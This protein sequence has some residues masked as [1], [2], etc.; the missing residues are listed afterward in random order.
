MRRHL[1]AG[2]GLSLVAL[3]LFLPPA[4]PRSPFG[5][6]IRVV[7]AAGERVE[8]FSVLRA[9]A[10]AGNGQGYSGGDPE[11]GRL[12]AARERLRKALSLI[13][14]GH[15]PSGLCSPRACGPG[16]G[17]PALCHALAA[18]PSADTGACRA[19]LVETAAQLLEASSPERSPLALSA[20]PLTASVPGLPGRRVAALTPRAGG[21]IVVHAASVAASSRE[22]LVALLLHE[23]GHRVAW[24][25]GPIDDEVVVT[26]T[27][28][29]GAALLDAAGAAIALFS[30]T[31][32]IPAQAPPPVPEGGDRGAICARATDLES[33]YVLGLA[34]DSSGETPD[35]A[36]LA[37]WRGAAAS[38]I[39]AG[40]EDAV[41]RVALAATSSREARARFIDELFRLALLRKP[42]VS[43][44]E[45]TQSRLAAGLSYDAVVASVLGD[46][47]YTTAHAH[48]TQEQF[49]VSVFVDLV[50]RLPTAGEAAPYTASALD[51][52]TIAR[53][54]FR[55]EAGAAERLVREWFTRY[56]NREPGAAERDAYVAMVR[57]GLSW[58]VAR[59]RILSLPEYR[60]LQSERFSRAAL[61]CD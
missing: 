24:R 32:V 57:K 12:A 30:D 9:V 55:R 43:E 58:E 47:Q 18:L 6:A 51:H 11:G 39:A 54:I 7:P 37:R 50:G 28:S 22:G 21:A 49:V 36:T 61:H 4:E 26:G 17:D 46:P 40:D 8:D 13:V 15:A 59:A 16:R 31:Q 5:G 35:G 23:I 2:I 27:S 42:T 45:R 29:R 1:L 34:L 56:L 38:A 52:A 60:L 53:R 10:V 41:A 25:G 3:A 48:G 14:R 20:M 19:F 33:R 44:L